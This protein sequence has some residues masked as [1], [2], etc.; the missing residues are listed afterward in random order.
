MK[1][2]SIIVPILNEEAN[3]H[4][5]VKRIAHT[6]K[7]Y[8]YEVVFID[9]HSTDNSVKKIRRL[10]NK[11][12]IKVFSKEGR[13]GKSF[14]ILEGIKKAQYNTLVF[15]DGDLQCP[16]EGIPLL[17]DVMDK[18]YD[19]VVAN[20]K[21]YRTN[22]V[23][24]ICSKTFTFLFAHL[25]HNIHCDAQ[26]GLKLAKKKVFK[27]MTLTPQPWTLDLEF[28]VKAKR[29]GYKIGTVAICFESRKTGS[30]KLK[31][32]PSLFQMVVEAIKLKFMALYVLIYAN[33]EPFLMSRAL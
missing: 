32:L 10:Q 23:R 6:L 1:S 15:I 14:S 13:K 22:I 29:N 30:T 8:T 3:I 16:P 18:G 24:K 28:L 21:E 17:I 4:E 20:R 31:I 26:S 5:L 11:Y 2:V 7:G 12:P 19:I 27:N 25:L 33:L 9:D